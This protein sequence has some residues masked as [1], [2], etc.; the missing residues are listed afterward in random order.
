MAITTLLPWEPD[1][2]LPPVLRHD[3]RLAIATTTVRILRDS[4][5][6]VLPSVHRVA[7]ITRGRVAAAILEVHAVVAEVVVA[8][9]APTFKINQETLTFNRL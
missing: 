6:A 1:I 9:D 5:T 2:S 8:V 7:P 4:T 3:P